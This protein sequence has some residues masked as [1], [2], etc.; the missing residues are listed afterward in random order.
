MNEFLDYL[1]KVAVIQAI[2]CGLFFLAFRNSGRHTL[3]RWVL[4]SMMGLALIVP[5]IPSQPSEK[6]SHIVE[7][8]VSEF[9]VGSPLSLHAVKIRDTTLTV[10]Q[11]FSWLIQWA[12]ALVALWLFIRS[13]AYFTGIFLIKYRPGVYHSKDNI[14]HTQLIE[15][16]SFFQNIYLPEGLASSPNYREILTHEQAHVRHHHS[17]DRMLMEAWVTIFWFNPFIYLL[18]KLLIE[19]HEFQADENTIELTGDRLV[20]QEAIVSQLFG[21]KHLNLV[22]HFNY[23]LIKRRIMMIH[24]KRKKSLLIYAV[25]IPVTALVFFGFTK[26]KTL[27]LPQ[28]IHSTNVSAGILQMG[29]QEVREKNFI[30]SILPLAHNEKVRLTSTFGKRKDPFDHQHKMHKGV[31]FGVPYHTAVL[32][33]ADG[34]VKQVRLSKEGHGN[35]LVIDHDGQYTTRYAQLEEILVKEGDQVNIGQVVARSG[36]SGRST[37]PHL[38]YEV[39]KTDVGHVNPLGF[40]KDYMFE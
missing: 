30:P 19:V 40:I 27:P 23:S 24:Q 9:E 20:Y 17:I 28:N 10:P 18:R 13:A 39:I 11:N 12:Y 29:L 15:P 5:L 4:L 21:P 16:F 2:F 31:D 1:L 14:Y 36:S 7:D 26:P 32:S 37:G 8:V 38:H 25:A 22:N 6:M 33:A 3:N 35:L 34:V